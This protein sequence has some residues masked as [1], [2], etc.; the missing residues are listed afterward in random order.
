MTNYRGFGQLDLSERLAIE[1]G[2][3]RGESFKKIAKTIRRHPSTVSHEVL[4]NRTFIHGYYYAGKDCQRAKQCVRRR[5]M[6]V[7][8]DQLSGRLFAAIPIVL[9]IL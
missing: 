8:K 6:Q 4:A 2:L 9:I 1:V 5:D 7:M 3:S